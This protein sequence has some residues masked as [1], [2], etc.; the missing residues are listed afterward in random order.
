M[1]ECRKCG[2]TCASWKG[3]SKH[4]RSS[5]GI[6]AFAYMEGNRDQL[7]Q[8]IKENIEEVPPPKGRESLGNCW[9]WTGRPSRAKRNGTPYGNIRLAGSPTE[10]SHRVSYWAFTGHMPGKSELLLHQCDFGLCANP[11]HMK[12][13][14]HGEN[15]AER[16]ERDRAS[17]GSH[18]YSTSLTEQNVKEIR[19]KSGWGHSAAS[20]ARGHGVGP[21]VVGR[22]LRKETWR[23]VTYDPEYDPSFI[24]F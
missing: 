1:V 3:L 8:R 10:S 11:G 21:E 23:H 18:H 12:L 16:G 14:T 9:K 7:Q 5:H 13:G 2:K 20:I 17:R 4:V 15:M 22:I 6:S 19:Q 24:P